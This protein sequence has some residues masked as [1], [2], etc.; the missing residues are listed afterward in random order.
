MWSEVLHARYGNGRK[1]DATLVHRRQSAWWQDVC[2]IFDEGESGN[3]FDCR[4]QWLLGDGGSVNFW[5]DR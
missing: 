4:C 2:R 1:M 5:E 3:W